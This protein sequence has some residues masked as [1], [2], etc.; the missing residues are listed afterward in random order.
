MTGFVVVPATR[1]VP[2]LAT[3]IRP[4]EENLTIDPSL[5]VSVPE[6]TTGQVTTLSPAPS[7]TSEVTV[8]HR[9]SRLR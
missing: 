9:F 7:H 4:E 6:T 1:S 8:P 5:I 3:S 2:P